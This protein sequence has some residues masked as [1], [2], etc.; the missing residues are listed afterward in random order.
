MVAGEGDRDFEELYAAHFQPLTVQLYV[1]AGDLEQARDLVQEA[2]C[3]AY[4]RWSKISTY[5]DP[6]GWVRRVA[7]NLA[8][9]RWRRLRIAAGFAKQYREEHAE[10]PSPD[11][12]ALM[13]AL[14][15]LADNHRRVVVLHYLG[16]MAVADIA[17]Q[18][19]VPVGT[20][21]SW[22]HRGR[23]ALAAQLA[24]KEV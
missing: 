13:R 3:R 4:G 24:D 22:L 2:F 7:W 11:R 19:N 21:K 5:E 17:A 15:E 8:T 23:A 14:S 12:V 1:Y 6:L 9:S 20:V 16:D 10:P 18:E